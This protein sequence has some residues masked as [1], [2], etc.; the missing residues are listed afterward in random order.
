M[1]ALGIGFSPMPQVAA[2]RAGEMWNR[3]RTS[4]KKTK[5]VPRQAFVP[6]F[7]IGAHALECADAL[8]TRDRGFLRKWF[9][10]LRIIDPTEE[11][12]V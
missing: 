9:S 10:G 11:K 6:D 2:L 3:A 5:D 4:Q 7:L 12:I 8:I 1:T